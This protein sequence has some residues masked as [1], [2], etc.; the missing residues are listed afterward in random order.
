MICC[1]TSF[2][3]SIYAG[4]VHTPKAL[5]WLATSTQAIS[6]N[7]LGCYE[8]GNALRFAEFRKALQ[9]G[10]AARC[11]VNFEAALA[12][13]RLRM[14]S[15]NL[16]DVMAEANRLS[17]T[18]TLRGGHRSFDILHVAAAVV[19]RAADFLTFDQ[20]QRQLAAAEGL[21]TPL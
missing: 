4:D 13:N 12:K 10:E 9:A 6:V 3:F 5:S 20:K 8:L 2:L 15:L 18:H 7:A 1:D 21:N 17:A 11:W 19:L 14:S 16:A